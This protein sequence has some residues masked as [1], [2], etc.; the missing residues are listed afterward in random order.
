MTIIEKFANDLGITQ[1]VNGSWI[2]AIAIHFGA[3]ESNGLWLQA[4][5]NA[6]GISQPLNGSWLQAIA[7]EYG[8]FAPV[9]G[10]WWFAIEQG[11]VTP[12]GDW[13]LQTGAWNDTGIW[14]DT[15]N[16]IDN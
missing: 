7:F 15:S 6:I 5:A 10:S 4:W 8:I 9:N 3:T 12:G 14:I 1:P 16:W 11:G 13:I 2:E